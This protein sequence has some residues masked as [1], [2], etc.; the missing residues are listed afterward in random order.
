[1]RRRDRVRN[2]DTPL[3]CASAKRHSL[4]D[5]DKKYGERNAKE[6]N[7]GHN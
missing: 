1:M 3:V 7:K 5:D 6:N 2:L 4:S